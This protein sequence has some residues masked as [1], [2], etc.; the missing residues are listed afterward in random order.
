MQKRVNRGFTLVEL[1]VVITIISILAAILFPVFARVREN[2]RRSSCVSNLKQL[3]LGLM[4]YAQDNDGGLPAYSTPRADGTANPTWAKLYLPTIDYVKS[5]QMYRCPSAPTYAFPSSH[6][7]GAQYGYTWAN[8]TATNW[9]GLKANYAG[10]SFIDVV[11]DPVRTCLLGDGWADFNS[12]A[13]G[14][15]AHQFRPTTTTWNGLRPDAHLE[16]ANY[17]FVD[18][19]VKWLKMET[20]SGAIRT[21][22]AGATRTTAPSLPI[23]FTWSSVS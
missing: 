10:T 16:G 18:G 12:T 23:I 8:G 2:A 9:A 13:P 17:A 5:D 1:L 7:Y 19:H 14:Q 15:G 21:G 3:A 22:A 4:M 11:P 6:I 20:V